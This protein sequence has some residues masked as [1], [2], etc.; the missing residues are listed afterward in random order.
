MAIFNTIYKKSSGGSSGFSI[1][2]S[3]PPTKTSY[4][5]GDTFNPTGMVVQ[6]KFSN[7]L[8]FNIPHE[9]LTFSPSGELMLNDNRITVTFQ[10]GDIQLT[11]YQDISVEEMPEFMWK[12]L[13]MTSDNA[14]TPLV[15]SAS[16]YYAPNNSLP[17]RAF[18]GN[19]VTGTDYYH[20]WACALGQTGNVWLMIDFGTNK[21]FDAVR[22][23][24]IG[25]ADVYTQFPKYITIE[26]SDG[27][28]KFTT[29]KEQNIPIITTPLQSVTIDLGPQIARFVRFSNL[30][31]TGYA[32]PNSHVYIGEIEFHMATEQ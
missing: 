27:G 1:E 20:G 24:S 23:Y 7:G 31:K 5:A 2:I 21:K 17:F 16:S 32:G 6:G 22:L 15:A 19:Q 26:I 25:T 30:A 14:P 18:D 29:I 28:G 3:T 11:V 12:T 9:Y 13:N 8:T 4:Y 10:S